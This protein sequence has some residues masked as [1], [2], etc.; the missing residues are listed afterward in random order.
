MHSSRLSRR[1]LDKQ[2]AVTLVH[3]FTQPYT[4]TLLLFQFPSSHHN[5]SSFFLD[6]PSLTELSVLLEKKVH[7]RERVYSYLS[8][9]V[10]RSDPYHLVMYILTFIFWSSLLYS[11]TVKFY[12]FPELAG[13]HFETS[14]QSGTNWLL[15]TDDLSQHI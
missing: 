7:F 3:L 9:I 1:G 5:L 12:P 10:H 6:Q 11:F 4:K 15:K 8:W 14:R 2:A 13:C